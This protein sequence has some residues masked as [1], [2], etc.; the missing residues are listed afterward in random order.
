MAAE[1]SQRVGAL[2]QRGQV[3][4]AVTRA[5][6][7]EVPVAFTYGRQT[8]AVM[9]A[10]PCDLED[11]AV[12]FS[13]TE[14]IAADAG[15]IAGIEVV[16]VAEGIELRID[17]RA[18][19]A[20]R[21]AARRRRRACYAALEEWITGP[22]VRLL[23]LRLALLAVT[24]PWEEDAER[25]GWA[26][27][28]LAEWAPEVLGR[29]F[30]RL[31]AAGKGDFKERP[32]AALHEL[33]IRCKKLRYT[34]EIMAP[35]YPGKG[36][37]RFLRRLARLSERLGHVNDGAVAAGLIGEL[38]GGARGFA[39]GVVAGYLAGHA[40]QTRAQAAKAWVRVVKA[41]RFWE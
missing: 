11:F 32:A 10:S 14:E 35:L 22:P 36:T 31:R 21:L 40:A 27:R 12:G 33:R 3:R 30:Q 38:A 18:Q 20:E 7:E 25:R 16:R 34:A 23:M 5:V 26:A 37:A 6:P 17:L 39:G 13:L 1:G 4:F 41:K 19:A 28:P 9:M 2:A 24:R 8:H 15:A 29:G